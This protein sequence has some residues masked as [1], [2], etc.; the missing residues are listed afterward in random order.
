[1]TKN[2]EIRPIDIDKIDL[3]RLKQQTTDLP[4]LLQFAHDRSSALINPEDQG[5]IKARALLAMQ[6]QTKREFDQILNLIHPLMEQAER[7]KKR[8]LVSELIYMAQIPF[9]PIIGQNYY[10]YKKADGQ[11]T[12]SLIS[13][14]EWG[15]KMPFASF[16]GEVKLLSDHTW[17]LVE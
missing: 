1:M 8:V 9:D 11:T 17:E 14:S 13:P 15:A 5:K 7:L 10:V 16:E 2:K 3:E 6:E 12:L 4:S